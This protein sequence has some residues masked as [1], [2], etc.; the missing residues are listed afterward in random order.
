MK[1]PSWADTIAPSLLLLGWLTSSCYALEV[2][3]KVPRLVLPDKGATTYSLPNEHDN[4]PFVIWMPLAGHTPAGLGD[5]LAHAVDANGATL[6]IIP[7]IGSQH[8][9]DN[10]DDNDDDETSPE[11]SAATPDSEPSAADVTAAMPA[12]TSDP[13]TS[14]SSTAIPNLAEATSDTQ[15]ASADATAISSSKSSA[16]TQPDTAGLQSPPNPESPTAKVS[17]SAS[18]HEYVD[19]IEQE[20]RPR[21][22]LA[23]SEAE[24]P[25]RSALSHRE[26]PQI[27][28]APKHPLSPQEQYALDSLM[29]FNE[30][31]PNAHVLFDVEG[32]ALS[33]YTGAYITDLTPRPNL[34]IVSRKGL[35]TWSAFY[36]GVT[37]STLTRV[38]VG[39]RSRH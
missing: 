9:H 29:D 22:H 13:V 4:T 19:N 1:T 2:G 17:K 31:Y 35:L 38:I 32:L 34:F 25:Q 24:S 36:P 6:I 5:K 26:V 10:Y 30:Q 23:T 7:V 15:S 16:P 12:D 21:N 28:E 27:L 14:A 20:T 8:L 18:Y 3:D 33:N 39:A 11:N 37:T